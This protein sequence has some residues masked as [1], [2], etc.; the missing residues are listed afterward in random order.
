MRFGKALCG[1]TAALTLLSSVAITA[2]AEET[3][4]KLLTVKLSDVL[5][6]KNFKY[7][8]GDGYF[9]DS[10]K[11]Y[12]IGESEIAEWRETG[13][14]KLTNIESDLNL[15]GLTW[16]NGSF[17]SEYVQFAKQDAN[18]NVTERTVVSIDKVNEKVKTAYTLGSDW[19]Y[20][21]NDGYTVFAPTSDVGSGIVSVTIMKPDGTSFT[22]TLKS[23]VA[24]LDGAKWDDY[25]WFK[26]CAVD[27]EKYCC[28]V[29]VDE[30]TEGNILDERIYAVYGIGKDGSL[31]KIVGNINASSSGGIEHASGKNLVVSFAGDNY[32]DMA[33]SA[34]TG[35][36]YRFDYYGS[37]SYC[38]GKVAIGNRSYDTK[39]GYDLI[40]LKT[41]KTLVNYPY[42]Y[43]ND[44]GIFL[45]NTNYGKWGYIDS[46]GRELGVF[47]SAGVFQGDYAPVVKDGKAY[48]IDRN[49]NKISEEIAADD[50]STYGK[51]LFGFTQGDNTTLVT[52]TKST[53]TSEPTSEPTSKPTSEPTSSTTTS[54]P[55]SSTTSEPTSEPSST[56]TSST[57]KPEGGNPPTGAAMALLPIAAIGGAVAVVTR[58]R[59][60]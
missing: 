26:Y 40:D 25:V 35:E 10:R 53:E 45:V 60:K 3:E 43:G 59:R 8:L 7:G 21:T 49:M 57:A 4:L 52:Y 38:D 17:T 56:P 24:H 1:M 46:T 44:K 14:F 41:G 2:Q 18:G 6:E 32:Y 13:E 19:C 9:T 36:A 15:N 5:E 39:N 34:D 55:T 28:Y 16:W 23:L 12:R 48:L 11:F 27:D 47:D 54:E 22:T 33:F 31:T 29:L 42:I 50:V 30:K 58:K 20:T 51:E 37:I